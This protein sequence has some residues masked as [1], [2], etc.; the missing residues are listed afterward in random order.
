MPKTLS[1]ITLFTMGKTNL[2]K[3][4][5]KATK[6]GTKSSN[7]STKTQNKSTVITTV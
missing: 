1:Q 2:E 6:N 5:L 7:V 3:R 4:I